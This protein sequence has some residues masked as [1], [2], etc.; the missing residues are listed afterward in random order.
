MKWIVP[1]LTFLFLQH[2]PGVAQTVTLTGKNISLEKTFIELEAQTGY[3]VVCNIS[4]LKEA[5]PITV[6][7]RDM[8]LQTFLELILKNQELE[9]VITNKNIILSRKA[10]GPARTL[11]EQPLLVTMDVNGQIL[12]DEGKPVVGA[13]VAIKGTTYAVSADAEGRFVLKAVAETAVVVISAIGFESLEIGFKNGTVIKKSA[14]GQVSGSTAGPIAI[15]L[16][17]SVKSMNEVVVNAGYYQTT[18]R[19][20]TGSVAVVKAE[21][22]KGK[23]LENIDKLLQGKVPGLSVTSVT[24]RPGQSANIRIRGTNTITGNAEPLWVVDGVPLQKD[25]PSISSS[26]IKAG[27]FNTIFT[28]GIAGINPNDIANVTVLK[29]AS[30]AAIYGSRAAGGVIVVT[31]KRGEAGKMRVS[32]ST[33]ASLTLKP[34]RSPDLMN[35]QEK[36]AWEEQLWKDFSATGYNSNTRYPVVGLVGMVRSG[37]APFKGMSTAEQD[38]YLKEAASTSTDWFDELFR[39]SISQSHYLSLSGGTNTSTYYLSMGY[40]TN[41]GLVKKTSYDRY[42]V[43]AKIDMKPHPK[44]SMGLNTDLSIQ[45]A[46]GPSADQDLFK[47]AYFANP[48]EKPY[49]ADGSYRADNTFYN[50]KSVNGGGFDIYTPPNGVNIFREINETSNIGKNFSGTA[51]FDLNY[52]I[53]RNFRFVGLG[54]YSYTDNRSDNINGRY[55][56]T[57]F[58]DRLFF[59]AYPSTRTYGSITQTSANTSGYLLRGQ[60]QYDKRI[61]GIHSISAL[62]GSEI[63]GQKGKSIFAKRYG[64]DEVTGNAA[65]P[66]PPQGMPIDYDKIVSYANL[67]NSLSGQSIVEDAFAS[68]YAS[69]DYAFRGKYIVSATARTDGSNNFGSDQQFNPTW[70]LG[71]SWNV[72]QEPF[73]DRIKDVVN[74]LTVR[75][76]TGFTGNI[77]KTA[78]PQLIMNYAPDFRTTDE[79]YYRMGNIQN[80]PNKNLRWEKTRDMKAAVDFALFNSRISGAVEVYTRTSKDLVTALRVPSSTGFTDQKFNTSELLNRGVEFTLSTVNIKTTDLTWRTSFNIAYNENRL[81]RFT[82]PTGLRNMDVGAQVGYPMG[83]VFSGKITGIDPLTGMYTYQLRPD[84]VINSNA[85]LRDP[86]NYLFYLGTSTAPITGGFNTSVTYKNLTLNIGGNYSLNGYIVD[87]INPVVSYS[88]IASSGSDTREPIPGPIYDLYLNHLNVN[89]DRVN[90]WTPGSPI[91]NG[92]PRLI[93][94]FASPL[95]FSQTS[96]TTSTITDA[97][98]LKNISYLRVGS[99]TLSYNFPSDLIKRSKLQSLGCSFSV[100]NL[101][102]LTN[103]DGIDPESAGAVYPITRSVSFGINVGF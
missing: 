68:F 10:V 56:N 31:T 77:N 70:S 26:Q 38:A 91:I 41:N 82:T 65:M 33:N 5:K 49:N 36:I 1:L 67:M 15:T 13:T 46:K 18:T 59:D 47:Y 62:A 25:I 17:R 40:S 24:G 61:N 14:S 45:T 83:A 63:R 94:H 12:D 73:M 34:Q 42:N 60:L 64:Y 19:R 90:R 51:T 78:F 96:P 100:T 35:S 53:S 39:N 93:D 86:A 43:N 7:A 58:K 54:S 50:L 2:T 44:L 29:D 84:A 4:L 71:L 80:A 3:L 23:P 99:L 98:M 69:S 55:T 30:A 85:D 97:T 81:T 72:D 20:T 37:Q 27:D 66:L 52:K 21:E 92:Y 102:T 79:D 11:P 22:L 32:Y 9:Y 48:Y 89:K 75:V 103:Y 87:R 28:G 6:M 95:Y 8:P 101:F 57:A 16:E 74:A 88:T 76:A